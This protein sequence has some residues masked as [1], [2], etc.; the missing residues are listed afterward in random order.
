MIETVSTTYSPVSSYNLSMHNSNSSESPNHLIQERSS[1][2][3]NN[4]DIKTTQQINN[5]DYSVQQS[6]SPNNS[7]YS[8]TC[9]NFIPNSSNQNNFLTFE[10]NKKSKLAKNIDRWKG[11]NEANKQKYKNSLFFN[12]SESRKNVEN[13]TKS[14]IEERRKKQEEESSP[15]IIHEKNNPCINENINFNSQ[16]YIQNHYNRQ[17]A[18]KNNHITI[19]MNNMT[20]ELQNHKNPNSY[21]EFQKY[22]EQSYKSMLNYNQHAYQSHTNNVPI[23]NLPPIS[24]N[25]NS[26]QTNQVFNFLKNQ[27]IDNNQQNYNLPDNMF[28]NAEGKMLNKTIF[29]GQ[30]NASQHSNYNMINLNNSQEVNNY[31]SPYNINYQSYQNIFHSHNLPN[32]NSLPSRYQSYINNQQIENNMNYLNNKNNY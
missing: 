12:V 5:F 18:F 14:I 1:P 16:N 17:M 24:M 11:R 21:I 6:F 13:V 25:S 2:K 7:D 22:T 23:L 31:N 10:D 3:F 28:R 26:K 20:N 4:C 30:Y 15:I 29:H 32:S 9:A 19:N 27:T 8:S